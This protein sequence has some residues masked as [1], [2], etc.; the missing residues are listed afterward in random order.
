MALTVLPLA[1]RGDGTHRAAARLTREMTLT[2][3]PLG[4]A[5]GRLR[6]A[7]L[8]ENP[9]PFHDR[10]NPERVQRNAIQLRGAECPG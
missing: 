4:V 1:S 5:T 10:V 6:A 7:V 3:L 8:P 9:G 2:V